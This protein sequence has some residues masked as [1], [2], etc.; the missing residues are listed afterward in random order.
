LRESAEAGG[1]AAT[2]VARMA[3]LAEQGAM[4]RLRRFL[5]IIDDT[6]SS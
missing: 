1:E 5:L 2:V 3:A 4:I 6:C